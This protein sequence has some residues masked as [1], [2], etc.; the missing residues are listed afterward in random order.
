MDTDYNMLCSIIMNKK[1]QYW[2]KMAEPD[3]IFLGREEMNTLL[4]HNKVL[5]RYGNVIFGLNMVEVNLNSFVEIGG[6]K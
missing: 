6:M 1:K 4:N 2:D 5:E 3:Y